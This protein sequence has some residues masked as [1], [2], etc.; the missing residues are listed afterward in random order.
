MRK[1]YVAKSIP[2]MSGAV[3]CSSDVVG[4]ADP[5]D[6]GWRQGPRYVQLEEEG[7]VKKLPVANRPTHQWRR[8]TFEEPMETFLARDGHQRMKGGPVSGVRRRI[9]E[10]VF[11]FG[12]STK[13]GATSCALLP[14]DPSHSPVSKGNPT[15]RPEMPAAVPARKSRVGSS[16]S[17]TILWSACNNRLD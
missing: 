10:P 1:R 14:H 8:D 4:V 9:L 7:E 16:L 15:T 2:F 3:A 12:D 6:Q 11:H 13:P 17:K 5:S